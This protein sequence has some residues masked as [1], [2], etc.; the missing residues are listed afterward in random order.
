MSLPGIV[1]HGTAGIYASVTYINLFTTIYSV[2]RLILDE[3]FYGLKRMTFCWQKVT[4]NE[5]CICKAYSC[6]QTCL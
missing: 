3:K 6:N 2:V 5:M 1:R 4:D